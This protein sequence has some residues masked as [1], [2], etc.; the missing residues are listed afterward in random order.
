MWE[1]APPSHSFPEKGNAGADTWDYGS[2]EPAD[3]VGGF[4]DKNY[5][6]GANDAEGYAN[7][8]C[9]GCGQEG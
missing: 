7:E 6:G 9:F 5:N 2:N 1:E 3:N 8:K 4:D